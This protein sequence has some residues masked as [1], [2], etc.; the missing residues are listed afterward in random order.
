MIVNY[1]FPWMYT[2]KTTQLWGQLIPKDCPEHLIDGLGS[3]FDI[4]RPYNVTTT[5]PLSWPII[6][7]LL[8][9]T[10]WVHWNGNVIFRNFIIGFN[11]SFH[12]DNFRC[13]RQN[14]DICSAFTCAGVYVRWQAV[15]IRATARVTPSLVLAPELTATV[16]IYTLIH[17]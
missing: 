7:D 5:N 11:G 3:T 14:V 15:P 16:I 12:F 2:M 17:I 13:T 10:T 6:R 1:T 9:E 8:L 4:G